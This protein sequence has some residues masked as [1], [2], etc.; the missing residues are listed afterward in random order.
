MTETLGA[1]DFRVAD[2]NLAPF[3]RREIHL[4]EHEMPSLGSA[5]R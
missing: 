4:A 5:S 2:L 1:H 3:G